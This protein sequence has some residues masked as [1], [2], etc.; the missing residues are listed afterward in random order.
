MI[1]MISLLRVSLYFIFC[2]L[3]D[4]HCTIWNN[5]DCGSSIFTTL[6]LTPPGYLLPV[7][8]YTQRILN[9]VSRC[10]KNNVSISLNMAQRFTLIKLFQIRNCAF[11]CLE[12]ES[13]F[14]FIVITP[15]HNSVSCIKQLFTHLIH[16]GVLTV[17]GGMWLRSR[18]GI[19]SLIFNHP[20]VVII[21]APFVAEEKNEGKEGS[22]HPG[23]LKLI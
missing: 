8:A 6:E 14:L 12:K 21:Y 16:M 10:T 18:D 17:S 15:W 3:W 4:T 11:V 13:Y 1:V 22:V 7:L 20:Q 9:K 19:H 23:V 2:G 5:L